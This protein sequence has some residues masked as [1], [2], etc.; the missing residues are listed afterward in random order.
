M[1]KVSEAILLNLLGLVKMMHSPAL[2]IH[3]MFALSSSSVSCQFTRMKVADES[4]NLHHKKWN[5]SCC[6]VGDLAR[7]TWE[8]YLRWGSHRRKRKKNQKYTSRMCRYVER[9]FFV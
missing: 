1:F 9:T 8:I 7:G 4:Q 6:S 3:I 2:G 5:E